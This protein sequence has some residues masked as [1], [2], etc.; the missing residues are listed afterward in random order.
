[1]RRLYVFRGLGILAILALGILVLVFRNDPESDRTVIMAG[2]SEETGNETASSSEESGTR[3]LYVY[4]TGAV[5]EPGVYVLPE[6]ARL[7]EAVLRA[8]GLSRDADL[9]MINEARFLTDGEHIHVPRVGESLP[10]SAEDPKTQ[11]IDINKEG[12]DRLMLLPGIGEAKAQ[13]IVRYRTQNGPFSSIEDIMNVSGIGKA[14]FEQIK[15][16]IKV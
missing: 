7:Y 11:V 10:S 8:G 12:P 15:D 16:R 1:M 2:G 5:H 9:S 3:L 13:A 14:L 4:L 6:G